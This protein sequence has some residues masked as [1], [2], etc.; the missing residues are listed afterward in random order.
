MA[1]AIMGYRI[2]KA[3]PWAMSGGAS[4][5]QYIETSQL[6]I[7]ERLPDPA[8]KVYIHVRDL[9]RMAV[10][11]TRQSKLEAARRCFEDAR[12]YLDAR[13]ESEELQLLGA[14]RIDQATAYLN[15]QEKDW[16]QARTCILACLSKDLILETKYGYSLFHIQRVHLL[17]LLMRVEVSLDQVAAA[18]A[19]ADACVRY[20]LGQAEYPPTGEGWHVDKVAGISEVFRYGMIARMGSEIGVIL[21]DRPAEGALPLLNAF[22]CWEQLIDHPSLSEIYHWG[23]LKTAFLQDDAVTFLPL[24]SAFLTQGRRETTLWYAAVLDLCFVAKNIRPVSTRAFRDEIAKDAAILKQL[25]PEK[26]PGLLQ[27]KLA[28]QGRIRTSAIAMPARRFQIYNLGL[29]RTGTS[30]ITALFA[31]YYAATE[32]MEQ[33]SVEQIITW[34]R[35]YLTNDDLREYVLKRDRTGMLEMDSASFNHFYMDVLIETFPDAKFIFTIRE[36]YA[37][38]NSF[39]KLLV[40][41][42]KKYLDMG[43]ET[44]DWMEAYGAVWFGDFSWDGFSSYE[45]LIPELQELTPKFI[46]C[47]STY[48]RRILD[49]LPERRSI[50]VHTEEI[51]HQRDMLAALVGVPVSTLTQQDHVGA[52]PDRENLLAHYDRA[53]FDTLLSEYGGDVVQRVFDGAEMSPSDKEHCDIGG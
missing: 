15:A 31:N 34:K 48:N 7:K 53:Q 17:H 51:S 52:A 28:Q 37:W 33:E 30:S 47:W 19:L 20:L 8:H 38:V 36:C 25:A 2:G 11:L 12:R 49:R 29:P 41:W 3:K 46:R 18:V 45:A 21:A 10:R 16:G 40:R 6:L 43:L 50:I 9:T 13:I 44:P 24:V 35:G 26:L 39:M 5:A 4:G 14:S 27:R 32:Y 1:G 23:Q 42:R 22:S